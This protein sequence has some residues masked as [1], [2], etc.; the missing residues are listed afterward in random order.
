M[1]TAKN[2][3]EEEVDLG[4]LFVIIGKGFKN[5]FNFIGSIFKG[6]FEFVIQI[7]LFVKK[8]IVKIGVATVLGLIIGFFIE[9]STTKK[10]TSDLLVEPNF[11]STSQLY[12]NIK[13]YNDL[14]KQKDT[15]GLEKTFFLNTEYAASLK[16]FTIEPVINENDIINSYNDFIEEA[17]TATVSSYS[18]EE[19]IKT[20]EELDYKVHKINVISEKNDVF[21]K[22]DE[23]IIKSVS[24]NK[25]FRKVKE[26]TNENLNIRD[27]VYRQNL[28]QIDSLRKVYMKVLI[29]EA[30]K[31]STGTSIDLGGNKL[32]TKELELFE[33][34]RK[35]I[36]D[37]KLL[38]EEK[39]KN[40]DVINVISNFQPVGSEL[41]GITKNYISLFGILGAALMIGFLLLLE[42]NK[43]LNNYS[44]K[45]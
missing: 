13:Y 27:S 19:F 11:K 14:V 22:L 32:T 30:R 42:L 4:S 20:F 44:N 5:F 34:N 38:S 37:L 43:F 17:D 16:E 6:I 18:F 12:N 23:I 35:I 2:N 1:S 15:V 8:H 28:S 7:L 25:Y 36:Y 31:E 9:S 45:K 33:T 41:N 26:I 21:S 29:E 24:N 3:N 10:Y 40:Y 39:S